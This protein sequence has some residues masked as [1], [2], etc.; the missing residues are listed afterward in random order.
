MGSNQKKQLRMSGLGATNAT[1]GYLPLYKPLAKSKQ[2]GSIYYDK[3]GMPRTARI[4]FK[5]R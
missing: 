2:D 3:R 5:C 1:L 4:T